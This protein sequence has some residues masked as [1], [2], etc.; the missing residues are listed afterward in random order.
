MV[1]EIQVVSDNPD[2]PKQFQA[3]ANGL[4]DALGE[5]VISVHH[6]GSTAVP[7]LAAKPTIDI[8]IVDRSHAWLDAH[9][10]ALESLGYCAKGEN[11]IPGR[12]YFQR[13]AGEDH[14]FHLHA[15]E[16]GHPD[17]HRHLDFRDFL[18]VHPE[19][20]RAYAALKQSLMAQYTYDPKLYTEGKSDFIQ[21]VDRQVAAWRT[22]NQDFTAAQDGF[23]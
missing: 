9:G 4:T 23:N 22:A 19:T 15:Y 2:W 20:A 1:R 8:L 14:L 17:I 10:Q 7:G 3:E 18:R 16:D 5:N 11:G 21:A 13:L 6:I 12:R